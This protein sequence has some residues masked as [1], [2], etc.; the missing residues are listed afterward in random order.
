MIQKIGDSLYY[1]ADGKA[2]RKI[3]LAF[4]K[5]SLLSGATIGVLI[6]LKNKADAIKGRICAD[7][8]RN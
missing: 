3:I 6:D 5:V 7:C 8:A 1:L 4:T 2:C